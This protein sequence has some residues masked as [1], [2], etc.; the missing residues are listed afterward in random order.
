MLLELLQH[1]EGLFMA[2]I[3][4]LIGGRDCRSLCAL[5][6]TNVRLHNVVGR[7][8]IARH[9]RLFSAVVRQ[10]GGMRYFIDDNPDV[11][12][13]KL[14]RKVVSY[15]SYN[16]IVHKNSFSRNLHSDV[17]YIYVE[18]DSIVNI[19]VHGTAHFTDNN[20]I[21]IF[22]DSYLGLFPHII[23]SRVAPEWVVRFI[24][25]RDHS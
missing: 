1:H 18:H 14:D 16:P 4:P 25:V 21:R 10:I 8:D 15:I 24:Y 22:T 11:V 9:Y 23:K 20:F 12:F 6:A 7:V 17:L 3:M 2:T 13:R 5:A 19:I